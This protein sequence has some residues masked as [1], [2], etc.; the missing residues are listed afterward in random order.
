MQQNLENKVITLEEAVSRYVTDGCSLS[1]GGIIAREPMA[2]VYEIVRQRRKNLTYI[3]DSSVEPAEIMIAGGCI[4]KLEAAYVWVGVVGIGH[5]YRRAVEKGIP[6][7]LEIEEY[8]NYGSSL[9]FLAGAIGAPYM[10]TQSLLGSDLVTH[11]PRIKVMEDPYGTGPVALVPAA[12]P[13]VAF[14]HVQRADISGNAQIW[15]M[16]GNDENIARAAK[17]VIVTCEEIV[18]TLEF[19]KIPNMTTVPSYCVSGVVEIPFGSHPLP[20]SG[21]YWMDVPFRR[22]MAA[23]SK[24][25]EGIEAWMD[26]WIFKIKDHSSRV[27]KIGAERLK[28]LR[29]LEFDNYRIP[30]IE[31]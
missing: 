8:S 29:Q 16:L 10:P 12:Q 25:R 17:E 15:G 19:R 5:N 11:N 7:Y 28:K 23:A 21:Y 6:H 20:V 31:G 4:R 9:R 13:D 2:V 3:T 18:P 14:I 26:K 27:E 22:E 24:T 30:R 1:F